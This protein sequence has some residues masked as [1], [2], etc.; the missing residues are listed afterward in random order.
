M[1][2]LTLTKLDVKVQATRIAFDGISEHGK[3]VDVA[4]AEKWIGQ[5]GASTNPCRSR[6]ENI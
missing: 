3:V 4:H 1:P 5:R 2:K 6:D